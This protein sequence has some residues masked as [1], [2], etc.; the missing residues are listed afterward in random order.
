M[1]FK[2]FN[3]LAALLNCHIAILLRYEGK[4]F[5]TQQYSNITI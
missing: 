2:I 5:V 3:F 1:Y 4:N